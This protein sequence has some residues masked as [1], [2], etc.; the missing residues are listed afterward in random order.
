[1]AT[2]GKQIKVEMEYRR[3]E[4]EELYD[5]VLVSVG[6]VPNSADLGLENTKVTLDEK[7]FIKVN[8][9]QQTNDP[10]IYAIGDIAG[11]ILLA[12]KAHKEARIAVEVINGGNSVR[13][14]HRDSGGG[15]HRPGTGLV[16]SD[17][18]R[19]E[20]ARAFATKSRNFRGRRRGARCRSTARTA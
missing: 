10:A 8:E 15:V 14:R 9:K 18:S 13:W 7:G 2:V 6:R 5:R 11:G 3:P 1:M 20:R 19:S 16:R 17:R 12:H 4:T